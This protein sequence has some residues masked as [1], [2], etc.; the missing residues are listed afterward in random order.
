MLGLGVVSVHGYSFEGDGW[1]GR[2]ALCMCYEI[3]IMRPCLWMTERRAY[4][5]VFC[6]SIC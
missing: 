5:Q 2:K 4:Y 3:P 1:K 6:R